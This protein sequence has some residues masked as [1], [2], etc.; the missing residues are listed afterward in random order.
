MYWYLSLHKTYMY[1]PPVCCFSMLMII[2]VIVMM[3]MTMIMTITARCICKWTCLITAWPDLVTQIACLIKCWSFDFWQTDMYMYT[4]IKNTI[5][6]YWTNLWLTKIAF[7]YIYVI[8]KGVSIINQATHYWLK[9]IR[10]KVWRMHKH[11]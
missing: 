6:E 3:M 7:R 4:H 2:M 5:Y 8:R 9:G 10:R 1:F 11:V